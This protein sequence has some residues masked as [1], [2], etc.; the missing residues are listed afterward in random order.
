MGQGSDKYVVETAAIQNLQWATD[1]I[2]PPNIIIF[3][4]Y[5]LEKMILALL[6]RI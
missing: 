6:K 1:P 3:G 4:I 5:G 2:F